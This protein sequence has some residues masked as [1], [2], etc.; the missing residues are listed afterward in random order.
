M[1]RFVH[2]QPLYHN[3]I[4]EIVFL[5]GI[6]CHG[7][8]GDL[9]LSCFPYFRCEQMR[10]A[11]IPADVVLEHFPVDGLMAPAIR[12]GVDPHINLSDVADSPLNI[13]VRVRHNNG[14]AHLVGRNTLQHDRLP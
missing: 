6:K 7:F 3:V 9:R 1:F 14:I 12:A 5:T 10:V 4:G 11:L 2:P 8:G 13:S